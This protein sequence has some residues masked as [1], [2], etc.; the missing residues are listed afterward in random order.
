MKFN[1]IMIFFKEKH[2]LIANH[3]LFWSINQLF[4][5]FRQISYQTH[6]IWLNRFS[7]LFCGQTLKNYLHEKVIKYFAKNITKIKKCFKPKV[8]FCF[9]KWN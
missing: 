9:I 3:L 4:N 7:T 8:L 6:D 5:N 2:Y 1:E